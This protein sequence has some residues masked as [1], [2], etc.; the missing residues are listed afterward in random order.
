M[1]REVKDRWE[2]TSDEFQE[3][4]DVTVGIDW[5][6]AEVEDADLLGD[7][8][9]QDVLELGCGGGQQTVGLVERGATVTGVDLSRE[10][11]CHAVALFAERGLDVGVVEGDVTEL[12]F[13]ADRFDLA[14][15]TWVFQ[16]VPDLRACFEE[17]HRVLRPDGRFVFSM[18]HPFFSL[19]DP[20]SHEVVESYFDTGRQVTVDGREDYP[21]L[22]TYRQKVS[23]VYNWLRDAGFD[24]E[25]MFEPGSPDPD[26]YEAGPWGNSPPELRAKFPRT[27]VVAATVR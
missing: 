1:S 15:N 24:V 4:A 26:D 14:F 3:T 13:E 8:S 6:W 25:R 21:D 27:L 11:L 7:L 10:Q 23:D 18:P 16:W 9:G 2:H 5:Q 20:D 19:A 17:T 12:P 22:V